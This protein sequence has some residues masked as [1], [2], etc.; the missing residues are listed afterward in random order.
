MTG[1][2]PQ[3][4]WKQMLTATSTKKE[5][6]IKLRQA[7]ENTLG[8]TCRRK[9]RWQEM[10]FSSACC[11]DSVPRAAI[12]PTD[13]HTC[14]FSVCP[15]PNRDLF[16]CSVPFSVP[17]CQVSF[18]WDLW[19]RNHPTLP[20][21]WPIVPFWNVNCRTNNKSSAAILSEDTFCPLDMTPLPFLILFCP[22]HSE[23]YQ[24]H[25]QMD[26]LGRKGRTQTP[27]DQTASECSPVE[28]LTCYT[29]QLLCPGAP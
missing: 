27:Q 6:I 14:I 13:T 18:L 29:P 16:P 23:Y 26:K 11:F 17:L 8:F 19:E 15:Q 1:V 3:H 12:V 22:L 25:L 9:I 2:L 7:W 20:R 10:N 4:D 5:E 24:C 21:A 28:C